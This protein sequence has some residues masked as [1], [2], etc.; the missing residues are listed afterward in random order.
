MQNSV[1]KHPRAWASM[2][3]AKIFPRPQYQTINAFCLKLRI[4]VALH[5]LW[6]L[7]TETHI[8]SQQKALRVLNC[9]GC[10]NAAQ[11]EHMQRLK[12]ES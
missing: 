8:C 2:L 12:S 5:L 9:H 4:P 11:R 1:A 7:H 6:V 10:I 3:T